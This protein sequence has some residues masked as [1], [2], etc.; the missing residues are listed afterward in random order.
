MMV[1]PD[2]R[3]SSAHLGDEWR[4]CANNEKMGTKQHFPLWQG[5]RDRRHT[6]ICNKEHTHIH[7]HFHRKIIK[8]RMMQPRTF[9]CGGIT[10]LLLLLLWGECGVDA[11]TTTTTTTC[12]TTGGRHHSITA[13]TPTV[14]PRSSTFRLSSSSSSNN[15]NSNSNSEVEALLAAAAKAR[16]EANRLSEVRTIVLLLLLLS[17][18]LL[19]DTSWR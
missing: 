17:L 7:F 4:C 14:L 19:C 5:Q 16:E 10:S 1:L 8:S 6:Y 13:M 3:D 12:H 18:L 15:N 11:F 9:L 2:S